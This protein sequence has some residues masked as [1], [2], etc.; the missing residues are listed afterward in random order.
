MN[1]AFEKYLD[2]VDR[3]LK[4]LPPSERVDII[5]EVKSS[6]LE[7]EQ[8]NLSQDQILERLGNPKELAKAYLGD[9]LEKSSGFSMT[10][11]LTICA[12]YSIVGFSGMVVIPCL[13]V[14][15]PVFIICGILC[16]VFGA[17]KMAD[18][19]FHLGLPYAKYIG[20]SL[21]GITSLNPVGEF[22]VTLIVG[23]LLFLIGRVSWKLLIFY[24]K[25]VS[26]TKEILSV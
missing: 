15:A 3:S 11:F 21:P 20:I 4:P 16:P 18:A 23:I 6:I 8:E 5:K 14:I 12:F 2:T 17:Y 9:L 25:K 19:L 10:R 22:A 7:M 26:R 1:A 24:C 13:A